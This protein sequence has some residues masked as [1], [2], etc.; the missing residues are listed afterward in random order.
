V[1]R[2]FADK[3]TERIWNGDLSR[4]IP[5]QIQALARRKL[6]MLDAAQRLDDLR[7]PPA[8]RLEALRAKRAGQHSI[9]INDQW[10]ICFVWHEGQ[11]DEVEIVDYH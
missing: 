8:N 3:E 2:S 6:R 4:R 9:R 10:R 7:I 1:I 5:N 11:C